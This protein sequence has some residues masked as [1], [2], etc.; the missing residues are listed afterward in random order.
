MFCFREEKPNGNVHA[1]VVFNHG[2][3]SRT[4]SAVDKEIKIRNW[5]RD[6][7]CRELGLKMV[8]KL[9]MSSRAVSENCNR[10]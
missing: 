7:D 6:V 4:M 3:L 10:F 9:F 8:T 2:S 5:F 1:V